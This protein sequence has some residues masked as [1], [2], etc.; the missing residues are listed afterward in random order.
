[1][2]PHADALVTR[3][4]RVL[5]FPRAER[6]S[7]AREE[8][9][10]IDESEIRRVARARQPAGLVGAFLHQAYQEARLRWRGVAFRT[11]GN[12]EARNAY[13]RMT[14]HD[15]EGVNARQAWANWRT[16]PRNLTGRVPRRAL[17]AVD[18]CCGTGQSTEVLA[19]YLPAGSRLLGLEANPRFVETASERT[20]V[21][22][23]GSVPRVEFRAQTVLAPFG[24]PDGSLIASG[25]VDLVNVS[26]AVGCHFDAAATARLAEEVARVVAPGGHA[27]VDSGPA[28]TTRTQILPL[29]ERHGFEARRFSRSCVFDRC[30]QTCFYRL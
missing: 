16:I 21:S 1:M 14:P 9:L 23:S 25:S 11:Q 7:R 6:R 3:S 22:R 8:A 28:G 15:L 19:Y 24:C 20:Y 2:P 30:G 27:L 5:T 18:L 12:D 29:F 26:G 17:R 13:A 10:T 4:H